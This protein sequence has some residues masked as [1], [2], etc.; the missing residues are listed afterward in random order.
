MGIKKV[1]TTRI[2]LIQP[3]YGLVKGSIYKPAYNGPP[4]GLAYIAAVLEKEGFNVKIM[5]AFTLASSKQEII[6]TL[7]EYNPHIVGITT[8]TNTICDAVEMAK[9]SKN[10][11]PDTK[12]V[13]GGP[14]V[15]ALPEEVARYPYVDF[16]VY[17]E[18]EYIMLELVKALSEDKKV[19]KIRGLAY[20]NKESKIVVTPPMPFIED[21]DSLPTPAYHL[22][23]MGVYK[24]RFFWGVQGNWMSIVTGRGCPFACI[25]C[26]VY[27]SQG[28]KH[29][30]MSADK[31]LKE[32]EY[33]YNNFNVRYISFDDT[34][35]TLQ[36][37]KIKKLC[38]EIIKKGWK[39]KW[40][41]NSRVDTLPDITILKLMKKAGCHHIYFGVEAGDPEI[42]KQ[43]KNTSIAQVKK[44]VKLTKKAGLDVHASFIIGLPGETKATVRRTFK[45][46]KELNVDTVSFSIATPF[47]NTELY[48]EYDKKGFI[49]TKDWCRYESEAV[50]STDE[51]S[52]EYLNEIA[53][54]LYKEYYLRPRYLIKK[55]L[56]IRS[57]S[58]FKDYINIGTDLLKNK[59]N[60]NIQ[61]GCDKNNKK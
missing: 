7:K 16:A 59:L 41:C 3:P 34:A 38:Q 24:P 52:S 51:L 10:I 22:L 23:P 2:L 55:L 6:Q 48:E 13:I 53:I 20:M 9:I 47:P 11:L 29:R 46:A 37:R 36:K 21:I 42:L 43:T 14:H 50:I 58:E 54:Q 1:H 31:I 56:K 5:D 60:V 25:F 4:L 45:L 27:R 26:D 39:L 28:R 12:V 18:G 44:A 32:M 30:H 8:L 17:G 57:I 33:L 40:Y 19:D 49:I 35:F 15:N 61:S